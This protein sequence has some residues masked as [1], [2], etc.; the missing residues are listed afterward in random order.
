MAQKMRIH[1][2]IN[3]D[4]KNIRGKHNDFFKD[5]FGNPS[6][7]LF[8]GVEEGGYII[9]ASKYDTDNKKW[10]IACKTKK[11]NVK[12]IIPCNG[13]EEKIVNEFLREFEN[14]NKPEGASISYGDKE[15]GTFTPYPEFRDNFRYDA[16]WRAL[17]NP[18]K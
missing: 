11:I 14:K 18:L 1:F 4:T 16:K 8:R 2:K 3:P 12:H 13:T 17:S 6:E 9:S 7:D 5:P 10:S 15:I